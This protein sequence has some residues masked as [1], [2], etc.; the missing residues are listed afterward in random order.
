V[1][2][3]ILPGIGDSGPGHWQTAWEQTLPGAI[4]VPAQDWD[5]P[6][7]SEWIAA[8]ERVVAEVGPDAILVAHSLGCLQVVHWA[9]ETARVVRGALLVAPPDPEAGAFPCD[10]IGF[11]LLPKVRLPFASTILAS[12][13][14]PFASLDFS[15]RCAE[16]WG[17]QLVALGPRGH[18]NADSA[19]GDWPEGR[20][21]LERLCGS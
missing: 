4:R 6:V 19:L 13:N 7:C 9:N 21:Y 12:T 8:L 11:R 17:S 14:D 20:L 5:H 15:H 16:A 1:S 3:L 18:I 2:F 10:A